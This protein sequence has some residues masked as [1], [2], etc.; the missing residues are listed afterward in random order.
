MVSVIV[1]A[2]CHAEPYDLVVEFADIA[3]PLP[4]LHT[5]RVD[6]LD[7]VPLAGLQKPGHVVPG[8]LQLTVA[9]ALHDEV[10]VAHGDED[11]LVED[12]NVLQL[13]MRV[14]GDQGGCGGLHDRRVAHLRIE[15]ARQEGGGHGVARPRAQGPVP[16]SLVA[17]VILRAQ[18][19]PGVHFGSHD[20]TVYVDAA[21]HDHETADIDDLRPLPLDLVGRY[22][23]SVSHPDVADLAGATV[24]R[25]VDPTSEQSQHHFTAWMS[26]SSISSSVGR[27][28]E[29]TL[30]NG[31]G[32]LSMR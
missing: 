7:G 16:R 30:R 2:R 20:V 12:G 26:R 4:V 10:V 15:V 21:G 22:D 18:S 8:F 19:A 6:D 14:P 13:L 17:T 29:M 31:M 25:V 28:E 1:L 24:L 23:A 32:T 9:D 3:P 27:P 11:A 5:A